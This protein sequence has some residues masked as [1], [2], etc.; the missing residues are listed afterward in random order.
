MKVTYDFHIHT[1]ASPCAD[2]SMTPHNIINMAQLMGTQVIAITDHNTCANCRSVMQVG[3]QQGI[4]VIPGM[5][6]ECQEEFHCIALFETLEA[7]E[8]FEVFVKAHQ[9][10]VL[11]KP[12]IF[13]EQHLL[14]GASEIVGTIPYLLL[15]PIQ[16]SIYELYPKVAALGGI[17]YPAHIDRKSYSILMTLGA[18]PDDIPFQYI[19]VAATAL[20]EVYASKYPT[21]CILRGSDAHY[22]QDL[23]RETYVLE[24]QSCSVRGIFKQLRR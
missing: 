24:T 22:L 5:E 6:V 7:A 8:A 17:L 19:E 4:V 1:D 12:H 13:G 11:N 9:L 18:L 15:T 10:P 20:Q 21:Y 14:D 2:T 16:L 23:C 3:K